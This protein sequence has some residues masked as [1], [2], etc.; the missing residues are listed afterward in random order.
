MKNS[1]HHNSLHIIQTVIV[2]AGFVFFAKFFFSVWSTSSS[3][4]QQSQLMFTWYAKSE[5]TLK[6]EPWHIAI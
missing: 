3:K 1:P 4:Y 2:V 6:A 5:S